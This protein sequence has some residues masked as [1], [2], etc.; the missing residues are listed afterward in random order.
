M[1]EIYSLTFGSIEVRNEAKRNCIPLWEYFSSL[2]DWSMYDD[3]N[4]RLVWLECQGIPAHCWSLENLKRIG[5]IWGQ[6]ECFDANTSK[7]E[8]LEAGR[9]IARSDS[10]GY[11]VWVD[12]VGTVQGSPRIL[13][14]T[15]VIGYTA[16]ATNLE[17]EESSLHSNR[18]ADIEV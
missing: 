18:L 17:K 7:M 15:Q 5:G 2:K 9:V 3:F 6:V 10:C 4:E 13:E 16:K 12:E 8:T 14:N 1:G 11:D